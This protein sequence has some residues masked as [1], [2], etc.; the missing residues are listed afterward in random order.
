MGHPEDTISTELSTL[1]AD[2]KQLLDAVTSLM[3]DQ[4]AEDLVVID[5]AGKSTIGDYMIVATGRSARHVSAL[6]ERT[7]QL[8]KD[9]GI[10]GLT[11]E[12]LRQGDWVLIDAGDLIVHLFRREVREFYN[13]EKMWGVAGD[14]DD[15]P[16]EPAAPGSGP[17]A[18]A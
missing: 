12:G 14:S 13:L 7:M 16:A 9:N 10:K 5:L 6:A 1:A 11:P 8:F 18:G 4:Q 15:T 17:E 2:P 3:D